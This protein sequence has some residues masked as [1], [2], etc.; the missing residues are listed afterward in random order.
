M[1]NIVFQAS[2]DKFMSFSFETEVDDM[3][4]LYEYDI[5]IKRNR[6]WGNLGI[7]GKIRRYFLSQTFYFLPL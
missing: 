3:A 6:I 2:K 1:G 4:Y 7:D 5:I